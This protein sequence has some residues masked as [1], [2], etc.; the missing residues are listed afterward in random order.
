MELAG[1][2]DIDGKAREGSRIGRWANQL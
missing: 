1:T 2:Q